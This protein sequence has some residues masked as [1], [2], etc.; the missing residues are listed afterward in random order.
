M[1]L[2]K[3]TRDDVHRRKAERCMLHITAKG[4]LTFS[5]EAS[6]A[7]NIGEASR[8]YLHQDEERP[9]DWYIEVTS[10]KEGIECKRNASTGV[11]GFQCAFL[12][13]EILKS[14]GK[15]AV[16][17]IRLPVSHVPTEGKL[18]AIITKAAQEY[19]SMY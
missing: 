14:I 18:Y 19:S 3:F 1:K 4:K 2:K 12:A 8:I 6:S 13:Q 10:D 7:L 17:S 15:S 9:I 16:K 11:L 5:R